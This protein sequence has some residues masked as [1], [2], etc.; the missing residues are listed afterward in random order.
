MNDILQVRKAFKC[1]EVYDNFLR[2]LVLYNQHLISKSELIE[3]LL[4]F[5]GYVSKTSC[6]SSNLLCCRK[7]PEL[8]KWL[9][10]F[11]GCNDRQGYADGPAAK[12]ADQEGISSDLA[13]EI[14][15][16]KKFSSWSLLR[17]VLIL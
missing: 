9:K 6:A 17:G 11:L 8:M 13:M 2:C 12:S 1:D 7:H 10:D 4:P 5:L 14:G 16:A 3:L 15:K